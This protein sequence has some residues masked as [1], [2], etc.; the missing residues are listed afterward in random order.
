MHLDQAYNQ[1]LQGSL[2]GSEQKQLGSSLV[3]PEMHQPVSSVFGCN[4]VEEV[5]QQVLQTQMQQ[6][7]F[8]HQI[9]SKKWV[10]SGEYLEYY[11]T[12][13][14]KLID[15]LTFP[16]VANLQMLLCLDARSQLFDFFAFNFGLDSQL[17]VV[18][19]GLRNGSFQRSD[20]APFKVVDTAKL[21]LELVH[22]LRL[23]V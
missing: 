21:R 13:Y 12:I 7:S 23:V 5:V 8:V 4:S 20:L 9:C 16:D 22:F 11:P 15:R 10:M 1:V 17:K 18:L 3:E 2:G 14:F 19:G 6:M